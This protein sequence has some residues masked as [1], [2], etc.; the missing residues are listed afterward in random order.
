MVKP[1]QF[2]KSDIEPNIGLNY[3]VS[4]LTDVYNGEL[5]SV[6]DEHLVMEYFNVVKDDTREVDIPLTKII[7]MKEEL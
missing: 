5:L 3:F 4:T 1:K 2:T 7:W 6:N